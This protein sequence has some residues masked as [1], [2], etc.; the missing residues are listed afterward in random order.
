MA[1]CIAAIMSESSEFNALLAW[2]VVV[3]GQIGHATAPPA[4]C[5]NGHP[6]VRCLGGVHQTHPGAHFRAKKRLRAPGRR[7]VR[8]V[9]GRETAQLVKFGVVAPCVGGVRAVSGPGRVPGR[10]ARR[11]GRAG[12][13]RGGGEGPGWVAGIGRGTGPPAFPIGAPTATAPALGGGAAELPPPR[14][15]PRH[16]GRTGPGA[17]VLKAG[18]RGHVD[19]II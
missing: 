9:T 1:P 17:A 5:T 3:S 18:W 2:R 13:R 6:R 8:A 15:A 12:C 7:A 14:D 19:M 4:A 11:L 16:R 10:S